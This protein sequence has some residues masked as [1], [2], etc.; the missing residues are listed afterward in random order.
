MSSH[1]IPAAF[2]ATPGEFRRGWPAVFACFCVATFAWGFGFYGQS[3]YFAALQQLHGWPASLVAS[4]TTTYYLAGAVFLTQV[5]RASALLGPRM[6]LG[7]G[8]VILG[9]GVIGLSKTFA[10]WQLY[11]CSIVMA[12]GWSAI[13]HSR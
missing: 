6:L 11:M 3:V 12:I 4:A 8:A 7:S 10:P 13:R 2:G 5:H 1:T 9:A